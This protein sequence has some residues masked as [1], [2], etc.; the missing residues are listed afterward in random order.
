MAIR[1][2]KNKLKRESKKAAGRAAALM[3]AVA[4]CAG[5]GMQ[6]EKSEK[7]GSVKAE[8]EH[9]ESTERLAELTLRDGIGIYVTEH[10][11]YSTVEE[12]KKAELVQ[13]DWQGKEQHR[14]P[15]G[16]YVHIRGISEK[17]VCYSEFVENDGVVLCLA[18]IEQTENGEEVQFKKK[19]KIARGEY[20]FSVYAWESKVYY[21]QTA[22]SGSDYLYCY[23]AEKKETNCLLESDQYGTLQFC[24][25][26]D[27]CA[28]TGNLIV[29]DGKIY[30]INVRSSD[31]SFYCVDRETARLAFLGELKDSKWKKVLAVKDDFIFCSVSGGDED[32][33][34][35]CYIVYDTKEKRKKAELTENQVKTFLKQQGLWKKGADFEMVDGRGGEKGLDFVIRVYWPEKITATGGPKKGKEVKMSKSRQILLHC[36]WQELTSL[37]VDQSFSQWMDEHQD[38]TDVFITVPATADIYSHYSLIPNI[39]VRGFYGDD[40]LICCQELERKK[41]S[42]E[43]I[44][45]DDFLYNV[46]FKNFQL[47]AFDLDSGEAQ[48][49]PKTDVLYQMIEMPV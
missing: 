40:L 26:D 49:I 42:E 28:D 36:P 46:E 39:Y 43:K 45:A 12:S 37:S 14:Y 17:Y 10:C 34:S 9:T 21:I 27:G 48:D 15:L 3:L 30:F 2:T 20:D 23:D 38:Y 13:S 25:Q 11:L 5:C 18:P 44:P 19:Q 32:D 7:N 31:A 24:N 22:D 47:R 33:L 1:R 4:L 8:K 29:H 41:T 6:A 35:T 16:E